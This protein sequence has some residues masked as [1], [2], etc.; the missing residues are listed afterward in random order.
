MKF[1]AAALFLGLLL[2]PSLARSQTV[3][4]SNLDIVGGGQNLSADV[5]VGRA[6]TTDSS[7]SAFT[8]DSVTLSFRNFQN[9]TINNFSVFI[10]AYDGAASPGALL[11]TLTNGALP[12][13]G[14]DP[15]VGTGMN[16]TWTGSGITLAAATNYF[17]I[18]GFTDGTGDINASSRTDNFSS[19][20][21]DLG[22][23]LSSTDGGSSWN[24][25]TAGYM[26]AI[27]ASAV[28]E[29]SAFALFVGL[30]T[31]GLAATRRRRL[32]TAR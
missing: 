9:P 4:V 2:L 19:G 21:W 25:T 30:V 15:Y 8:L 31:L 7:A 10:R 6:F 28:P 27:N 12:T 20:A 5:L 11:G 13:F 23:G 29:P 22:G 26:L 16:S 18:W 24:T 3:G 14:T 32:H 1:P 17:V